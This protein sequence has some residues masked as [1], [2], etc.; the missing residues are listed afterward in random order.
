VSAEL[1]TSQVE[2]L[3][4]IGEGEDG[5]TATEVAT[6]L[7]GGRVETWDALNAL[8]LAGYLRRRS[9]RFY[10]TELGRGA[11][12]QDNQQLDKGPQGEG[13]A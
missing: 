8:R 13:K 3:R 2:T 10:L 11:L 7:V 5:R 1:R 6:R 4:F 12:E 9:W